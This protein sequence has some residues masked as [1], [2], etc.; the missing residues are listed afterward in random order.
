MDISGCTFINS[1]RG[2][3]SVR[4]D[5]TSWEKITIRD[6]VFNRSGRVMKSTDNVKMYGNKITDH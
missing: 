4:L 5:E 2:G 1:G 3:A 6:C